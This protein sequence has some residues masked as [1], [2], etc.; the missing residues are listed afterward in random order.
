MTPCTFPQTEIFSDEL[1]ERNQGAQSGVPSETSGGTY[2]EGGG[3]ETI[4]K[5]GQQTANRRERSTIMGFNFE[6]FYIKLLDLVISSSLKC[7][8][9]SLELLEESHGTQYTEPGGRCCWKAGKNKCKLCRLDL[10]GLSLI[11]QTTIASLKSQLEDIKCINLEMYT[12]LAVSSGT[13]SPF[14]CMDWIELKCH[15]TALGSLDQTIR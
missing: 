7:N 3:G 6:V 1:R 15:N 5:T 9:F 11:A 10:M 14:Y 2:S 8:L 12:K 4:G 13:L